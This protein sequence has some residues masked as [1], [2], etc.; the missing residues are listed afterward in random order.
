MNFFCSFSLKKVIYYNWFF[1]NLQ[2]NEY[3]QVT[4]QT[5]KQNNSPRTHLYQQSNILSKLLGLSNQGRVGSNHR[6]PDPDL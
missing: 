5:H 1:H 6:C 2:I 4:N 3:C